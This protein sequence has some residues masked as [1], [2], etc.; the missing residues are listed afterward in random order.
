MHRLDLEEELNR[1]LCI[2]LPS[3]TYFE[4]VCSKTVISPYL[5]KMC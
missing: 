3:L 2:I 5:Q 1:L 4:L